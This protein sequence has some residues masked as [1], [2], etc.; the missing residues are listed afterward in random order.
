MAFFNFILARL[1][2]RSTWLGIIAAVTLA[3]VKI[4]PELAEQIAT[5]GGMVASAVA[6]FTSDKPAA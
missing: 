3:G 4:S 1:K 2:E 6:I 5:A